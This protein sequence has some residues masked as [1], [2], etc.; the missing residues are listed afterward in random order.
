MQNNYSVV[1]K[2][3]KEIV[4]KLCRVS[5]IPMNI[6][7]TKVLRCCYLQKSFDYDVIDV[8]LWY[9][10]YSM[11]LA[12]DDSWVCTQIFL[13]LK[14]YYSSLSKNMIFLVEDDVRDLP[15]GA[16]YPAFS[17]F[18]QIAPRNC[19]KFMLTPS[20]TNH[21]GCQIDLSRNNA[22]FSIQFPFS[23]FEIC[24]IAPSRFPPGRPRVQTP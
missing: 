23:R 22:S 3:L 8:S 11:T 19:L 6:N 16:R 24:P 18:A 21:A 5:I 17:I 10:T 2:I 9:K 1:F 7:I 20:L 14:H 13:S 4:M 15:G 12:I